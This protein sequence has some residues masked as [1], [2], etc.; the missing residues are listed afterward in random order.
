[1][2]ISRD[3]V[4]D[5][6]FD[7]A[8]VA[9]LSAVVV[10]I[11]SKVVSAI[12]IW[13][14]LLIGVLLFISGVGVIEFVKWERR[15]PVGGGLEGLRRIFRGHAHALHVGAPD[16]RKR[17]VFLAAGAIRAALGQDAEKDY[18]QHVSQF[19]TDHHPEPAAAYMASLAERPG[20]DYLPPRR[21]EDWD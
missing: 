14:L 19:P 5:K 1:M 15:K 6:G 20:L 18:W 8:I 11:L 2:R 21:D 13:E 4:T 17:Q 12:S 7:I 9:P 3:F 16:E 10:F